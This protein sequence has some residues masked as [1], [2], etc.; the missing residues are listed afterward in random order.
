M[1]QMAYLERVRGPKC[2]L[3]VLS[4]GGY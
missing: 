1:M 4:I 3:G 2:I